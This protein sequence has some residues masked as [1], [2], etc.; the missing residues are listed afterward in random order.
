M[1]LPPYYLNVLLTG[2]M[3]CVV[4]MMMYRG[5]I[6]Q[7]LFESFSKGHRGFPYAFIITGKAT[8]LEPIYGP[9][10]AD[11]RVFVLRGNQQVFD[12]AITFVVGL[13]AI[14]PTDLFNAFT[15]TLCIRYNYMTLGF[16]FI[17]GGLG[18]C[19][20]LAISPTIDLTGRPV[21][22]FLHLVQSLFGVFTLGECLPEMLHFFVEKIRIATNCFGPM[23]EGTYCT[24]FRQEVVVAVPL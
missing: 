24:K 18:T 8:T 21:K 4:A 11:D 9:T 5:G 19:S 7:V 10:F 23:V 12:G 1:P 14:P 16:H 15:E 17:G 13:Y 22:P 20:A 2:R 6:F 3:A